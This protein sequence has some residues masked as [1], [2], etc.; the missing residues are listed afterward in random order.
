MKKSLIAILVIAAVLFAGTFNV[1][2]MEENDL[3]TKVEATYDINGY[4]L[5]LPSDVIKQFEDYLSQFE[6]SAEDC[7]Y[8]SD[9]MDILIKAART[10]GVKSLTDFQKKCASEIRTACANVSANT[11][12]K[13]T[14]LSDGRVSVSKYNKPDEI[15]TILR[16]NIATNTGLINL[17]VIAGIISALG[18]SLLVFKV[19]KA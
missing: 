8:V 6:I 19:R 2:A 13:A 15:F 7:Q 12:I 5:R 3:K 18:A 1:Q 16:T 9:Q 10:K 11:G 14:V 17:F 4:S